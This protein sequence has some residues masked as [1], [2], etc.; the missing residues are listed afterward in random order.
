VT[1]LSE[2]YGTFDPQQLQHILMNLV[3]NGLK[4]S[5]DKEKVDLC[6]RSDNNFAIFEVRDRGIGIP[7]ADLQRLFEAFHRAKN[8]GNIAGTGLGM[9][10]VKRFVDCHNG[11]IDVKT[12]EGEGTMV[13][14]ELPLSN[15]TQ[16]AVTSE[17]E[18]E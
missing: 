3:S 6:L 2:L 5:P 8:V 7:N 4:Y 11:N 1:E 15:V 9:A 12:R 16:T 13:K 10:I 18:P 17:D 14:V